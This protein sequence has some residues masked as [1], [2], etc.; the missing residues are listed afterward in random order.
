MID[1]TRIVT[2]VFAGWLVVGCGGGTKPAGDVAATSAD[3]PTCSPP[4]SSAM[5][6]AWAEWSVARASA[7]SSE[8]P[9]C[10]NF[11]TVVARS[12]TGPC[13]L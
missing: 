3:I 2:M 13:R 10:T 7:S 6:I 8:S 5:P 4:T 11:M 9:R 1:L 12:K